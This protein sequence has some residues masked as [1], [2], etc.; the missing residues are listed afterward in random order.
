[1][2]HYRQPHGVYFLPHIMSQ[3][4]ATFR[5]SND[6]KPLVCGYDPCI[7]PSSSTKSTAVIDCL[8]N[9]AFS[10]S[11]IVSLFS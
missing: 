8:R 6:N 4:M 3:Q 7:G 9:A 10:K 1:L 5:K 2:F 11:G